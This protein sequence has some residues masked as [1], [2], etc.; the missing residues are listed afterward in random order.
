[1]IPVLC[2]IVRLSLAVFMLTLLSGCAGFHDLMG[3]GTAT[4]GDPS[5]GY[6]PYATDL[7]NAE[8]IR[9][10][11]KEA[12]QF[13]QEQDGKVR[14][15]LEMRADLEEKI[16]T[17]QE[18]EIGRLNTETE[19]LRA[20]V[21]SV[22]SQALRAREEIDAQW[23]PVQALAE[24]QASELTN[25]NE[26]M[27]AIVEETHQD[28]Q[29]LRNN[30]KNYRDALVQF[31]ALM[32]KLETLVLDEEFR[33]KEA[34]T[35]MR[36]SLKDHGLMLTQLE[37]KST[38]LGHL[39]KRMNQLHRYINEVQK[40]LRHAVATWEAGAPGKQ[41]SRNTALQE[42]QEIFANSP[43]SLDDPTESTNRATRPA[44]VPLVDEVIQ[45]LEEPASLIYNEKTPGTG[46]LNAEGGTT[47]K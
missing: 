18:T 5:Q 37:S 30:L 20:R 11:V 15:L 24:T 33:A 46:A 44:L 7:S 23:A 47:G 17:I 29:L 6:S 16:H 13:L 41:G 40:D 45:P 14:S 1:M 2:N 22:E 9:T 38:A 4:E 27:L 34:E 19:T 42:Q 35:D 26:S 31:H 8:E 39:Q 25:L 21:A 36:K 10:A 3:L 28:R 32:V 43:L 12:Q